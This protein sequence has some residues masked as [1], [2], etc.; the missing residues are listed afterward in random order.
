MSRRLLGLLTLV[1]AAALIGLTVGR[2]WLLGDGGQN[3]AGPRPSTVF[4][5]TADVQPRAHAFGD[6]VV[7]QVT[8]LVDRTLIDPQSLRLEPRFDPY[9]PAGPVSREV[10]E[11]GTGARISFRVPLVCLREGCEPVEGA[12]ALS[13]PS[14][15][16]FYRYQARSGRADYSFGWPTVEVVGRVP[17]ADVEQRRWR[18]DLSGLPAVSW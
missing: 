10:T 5:A 16:I 6:P 15:H 1:A 18:A 7:A 2:L 8:V 3:A 17:A 13:L 11:S 12:Q 4:S 9:E 14:G